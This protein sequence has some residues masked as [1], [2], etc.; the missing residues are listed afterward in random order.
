MSSSR[1]N[2]DYETVLEAYLNL[3]KN[4]SSETKRLFVTDRR[5]L[6]SE[7]EPRALGEMNPVPLN[8]LE[9]FIQVIKDAKVVVT[10]R[11][12]PAVIAAN[13]GIPF[14]YIKTTTKAHDLEQLMIAEGFGEHVDNLF[15]NPGDINL[16]GEKIN[17]L[18]TSQ[19]LAHDL[20]AFARRVKDRLESAAV[21][22]TR[23]INQDTPGSS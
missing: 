7:R 2:G 6:P 17:A 18:L 15:V 21:L 22:V 23:G 3:S 16:L 5:E 12:H 11:F 13:F 8:S 20:N 19:D 10:E 4:L 1:I 9:E 14:V